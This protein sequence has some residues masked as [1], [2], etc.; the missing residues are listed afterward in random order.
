MSENKFNRS[1]TTRVT[2]QESKV[3]NSRVVERLG[4]SN[5]EVKS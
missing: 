5:L 4:F 1:D 2:P 3:A